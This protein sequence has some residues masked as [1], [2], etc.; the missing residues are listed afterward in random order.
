[1]LSDLSLYDELNNKPAEQSR[2]HGLIHA[3]LVLLTKLYTFK[4]YCSFVKELQIVLFNLVLVW[5]T[6]LTVG[7]TGHKKKRETN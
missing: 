7:L 4:Y 3:W 1:M 6:G 2:I 5:K